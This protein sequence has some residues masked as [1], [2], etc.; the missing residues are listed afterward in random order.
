MAMGALA[1]VMGLLIGL[2]LGAL[3]GG[4]SILTVPALVYAL[5]QNAH[6]AT[7]SSLAVVGVTATAGTLAHLREGR[8]RV[9]EGTIFGGLGIAGSV[10]GSRLSAGIATA[11]L[12][13]GFSL[14]MLVAAGAMVV[15]AR[16]PAVAPAGAGSPGREPDGELVTATTAHRGRVPRPLVMLLTASGVGLLTGFFGVGGGFVV[17]PA[18]VLVMGFDVGAAVATSLLV[19]AVNSGAAL[20]GRIG[21][22]AHVDWAVTAVF[23]VAAMTASVLGARL[24]G[25]SDPRRLAR[26]FSVLLVAVAVYTLLRSVAHL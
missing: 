9:R 24:S 12:L 20:V 15:R 3:G 21:T 22:P 25:M 8:T 4:G 16:R 18:L 6:G 10:A 11:D 2:T 23:G 7:T 13:T 19:I 1:V 14:L 17:V 26:A 5:G